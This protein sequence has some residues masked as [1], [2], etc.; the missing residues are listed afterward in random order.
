MSVVLYY[1]K[2]CDNCNKLIYQLGKTK[3]KE[4][5]HFLNIDKRKQKGKD[6]YIILE[7][8]MEILMPS[9]INMVPALLL[10]NKNNQILFGKDVNNYLIPMI[11]EEKRTAVKI[12][13]APLAFSSYEMGMCMSDTYSYLD[14]NADELSAKG[15]GGIRQMHNYVSLGKMENIET[16]PE[17]YSPD[18]I[19]EVNLNKLIEQRQNEINIPKK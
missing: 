5:I 9:I 15:N 19:G 4:Q 10:L 13:G 18:K 1:S 8:G 6:T 17:D 16:P 12:N 2:Y 3:I 7:N 11:H 14:Q